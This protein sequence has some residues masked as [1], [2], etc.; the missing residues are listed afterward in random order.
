MNLLTNNTA[1]YKALRTFVQAFSAFAVGLILVVW[2][3][4]NVPQNVFNYIQPYENSILLWLGGYT[5]IIATAIAYIMARV[6][7]KQSQPLVTPPTEVVAETGIP[8]EAPQI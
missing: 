1:I 8:S 5:V 6:G 3:T 4:P 7:E 2:N